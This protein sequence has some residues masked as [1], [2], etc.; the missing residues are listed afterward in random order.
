MPYTSIYMLL[1]S[2]FNNL[3]VK[4]VND[5]FFPTDTVLVRYDQS[6]ID[7]GDYSSILL[8]G[9]IA[10]CEGMDIKTI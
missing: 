3:V 8:Y 2:L 7:V 9:F 4:Y 5:A 6:Y 1:M 10:L